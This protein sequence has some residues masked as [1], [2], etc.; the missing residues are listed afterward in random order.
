MK[1]HVLEFL[2]PGLKITKSRGHM[3]VSSIKGETEV[4]LDDITTAL[5]LSEDILISTNIIIALVER[6]VPI[7]FCD[8]KYNPTATLLQYSGHFQTQKR[9]S[10]QISLS[11]IQTGRLW[12][13]IVKKKIENQ[14]ELLKKLKLNN[15]MLNKFSDEV[16]IHDNTNIE[17]QAA[18]YYWKTLFGDNFRRDPVMAGTN[19]FLNYGYAIIRSAVARG[20]V[21]SGLNPS[22]GVHHSNFENPFCLVDDLIEPFRPLVDNYCFALKE[23]TEL[24]P[25]NKKKLSMILEHQVEYRG[26]KKILSSAVSE[27]CHSFATA[28]MQSEYKIFNTDVCLNLYEVQRV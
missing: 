25:A 4:P 15:Q 11:D 21:S 13:K 22:L 1:N 28:V 20:V 23:E 7:I 26:E 27:Y 18:R 10:A 16:E 3:L 24:S 12:Q 2:S 19:S 8:S 6:N 14:S 5:V 17:A 9:Q